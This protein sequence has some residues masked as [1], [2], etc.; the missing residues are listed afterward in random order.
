MEPILKAREV[1]LIQ[2]IILCPGH[3]DRQPRDLP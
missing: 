3:W 1:I 2:N